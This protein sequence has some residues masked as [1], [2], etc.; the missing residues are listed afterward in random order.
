MTF[1]RSTA[2]AAALAASALAISACSP[3]NQQDSEAKVPTATSFSAA[4]PQQAASASAPATTASHA[5]P[6][7]SASPSEARA[8][9]TQFIDCTQTPTVEPSQVQLNCFGTNQIT[10]LEWEWEDDSAT[11]RGIQINPNG[12]TEDATLELS[13]PVS[14]DGAQVFSQVRLNGQPLAAS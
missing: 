7:T 2:L 1:S 11:G 4:A 13:E 14:M 6:S 8:N 10:A 5:A 3:P 9:A 12:S